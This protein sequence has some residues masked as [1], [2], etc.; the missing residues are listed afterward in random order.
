M[1]PWKS[2]AAV[3]LA[4]LLLVA[5]SGYSLHRM[6]CLHSGKTKT[7]LF[8]FNCC[9][10]KKGETE[11]TTLAAKCCHQDSMNLSVD[12]FSFHKEESFDQ[13]DF[14][15]LFHWEVAVV[16]FS[17]E[18]R[19]LNFADSSPPFVLKDRYIRLQTFLC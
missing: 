8:G 17:T 5:G 14:S 2:I 3:F 19:I 6:V 13:I 12:E 7:S 18:K 9:K 15:P 10:D 1:R 16:T 4:G 11:K